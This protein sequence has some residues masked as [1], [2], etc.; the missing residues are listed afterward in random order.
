MIQKRYTGYVACRISEKKKQ[1]AE[2]I[3]NE[4]EKSLSDFLR[5]AIEQLLREKGELIE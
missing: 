2:A 3:L 5:E 4:Q 1:K